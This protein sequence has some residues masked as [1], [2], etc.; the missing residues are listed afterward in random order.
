MR[1]K[2]LLTACLFPTLIFAA[3]TFA[4]DAQ[5]KIITNFSAAPRPAQE[6]P[7]QQFE[8]NGFFSSLFGGGTRRN[9]IDIAEQAD[10][11]PVTSKDPDSGFEAYKPEPTYVLADA[12]LPG[13]GLFHSFSSSVL[14]V[15]Q[16]ET[17]SLEVRASEKQAVLNLYIAR[18]FE[19]IWVDANGI[20]AKGRDVLARLA[21]A[22]EDGL[23]PADYLPLGLSSF[24]DEASLLKG[25]YDALA[26]IDVAI[27]AMAAKFAH[28]IHS[29]RIVPRKLSGYYDIDQPLEDLDAVMLDLAQ[30]DDPAQVLSEA[31]PPFQPYQAL[32]QELSRQREAAANM[33]EAFPD[34]PTIKLGQKDERISLLRERM[35]EEGVLNDVPAEWAAPLA[36]GDVPTLDKALSK[37]LKAY[38]KQAGIKQTGAL[39]KATLAALNTNEAAARV[40]SLIINM[41]RLRW[42]PRDLG[43]RYVMANQPA[44]ELRIMDHGL[45]TWRTRVIIG[46]PRTQTFVFNEEMETVVFNPTWGVPQS[47]IVNEMLPELRRDP[48]YLDRLGYQVSD[49]QGKVIPSRYINW[50]GFGRSVPLNVVQPA[51]DDN[52]LGYVKFLFPNAH[53]IYMHDTPNRKLFE[54][55]VRAFSH[56][57][58][59]VQDPRRYAEILLGWT[60]EEV[61]AAIAKGRT[62]NVKLET[63]IPVYLHYF[64]A[65]AEPDGSVS[66]YDDIYNRDAKLQRALNSTV[67]LA[68]N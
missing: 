53:N 30:S 44:F 56:G 1:A 63:K 15:L 47:I 61:D 24:T 13:F 11:P 9:T 6:A 26:K 51:G 58:V 41:E 19:P 67:Q 65:F 38:Q 68:S 22:E 43:D 8:G 45:E 55:E 57:C 25:D 5:R 29:G 46:K 21:I 60:R 28:E 33:R 31:A 36:E 16:D 17:T 40:D 12:K 54:K 23:R 50:N 2:L 34:G 7:R 52:A 14:D 3:P 59:R 4:Q 27:S 39:D 42:L 37:A 20:N 64:T 49:N 35:Q 66:Y 10:L 48:S 32:K 62:Q 18:N